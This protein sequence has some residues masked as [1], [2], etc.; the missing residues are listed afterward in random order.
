MKKLT[1]QEFIERAK[2]VH[3]DKYSYATTIYNKSKEK[4]EIIC[5][6]HGP[7]TQR[8]NDHISD[9]NGCPSCKSE[10]IGDSKRNEFGKVLRLFK[11]AHGD[12]YDYSLIKFKSMEEKVPIIC[13]EHGIFMQSPNKHKIGRGCPRCKYSN[14]EKTTM[15]VLRDLCITYE[16]Q[17][18]FENLYGD[19]RKLSYDFYL[20]T[21]NALIE[22]DGEF[23]YDHT[24]V[25][26]YKNL[27][28]EE[29]IGKF[30]KTKEYDCIK[31][32]YAYKNG[33]HLLRIPF[34]KCTYKA[35]KREICKFVESIK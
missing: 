19:Y 6:K 30:L 24:K 35:I 32:T 21:L 20:P 11:D 34:S 8:P 31:N 9:K 28:E 27:S 22:Y 5:L 12:V 7:F 16:V 17:K 13:V 1:T 23:H 14:G 26:G 3:G 2:N 18:T 29:A 4:V 10:V 15:K 25:F 33:I